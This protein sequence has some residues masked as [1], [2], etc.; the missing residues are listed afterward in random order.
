M[1]LRRMRAR[2]TVETDFKVTE[3]CDFKVTENRDFEVTENSDFEVTNLNTEQRS[4][5]RNTERP[6]L[7]R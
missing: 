6:R 7:K 2:F 3:N 4:P 5:R 1:M